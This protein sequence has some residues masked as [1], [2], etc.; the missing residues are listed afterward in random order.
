MSNK[1]FDFEVGSTKQ[2]GDFGYNATFNLSHYI[3]NVE[4]I[5][6][7][8]YGNYIIKEG[9]PF[10]SNY[11]VECIGIFQNQAEIDASPLHQYNPKPGDLKFKDANGDGKIDANDRVV[12]PG[13]YPKFYYGGS[14]NLTWKNFDLSAFVQGV[15]GLKMSTQ[16]LSWGL[17][18]YIR[19]FY[20]F[21]ACNV[22]FRICSCNRYEKYLLVTRCI[23]FQVEKP[24]ARLQY[25]QKYLPENRITIPPCLYIG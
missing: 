16:G 21:S 9:L 24:A 8:S 19:R 22:Y 20:E 13:A 17:V 7:P 5:L 18:P 2:F 14:L 12:V 3:N 4:R 6:T 10:N 1:G 15:E 25:S 23:L 11:M